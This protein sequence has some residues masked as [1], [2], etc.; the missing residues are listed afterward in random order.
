MSSKIKKY[1]TMSLLA[2]HHHVHI[3]PQTTLNATHDRGYLAQ[4]TVFRKINHRAT[5][6]LC[7]FVR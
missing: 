2:L 4:P 1:D 3:S 5:E 6:P 7:V